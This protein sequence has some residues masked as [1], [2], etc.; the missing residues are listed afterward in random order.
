LSN[1]YEQL[2]VSRGLSMTTRYFICG[3]Q[4]PGGGGGCGCCAACG[5]GGDEE[6]G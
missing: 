1:V 6:G 2:P 5:G 4:L 3:L